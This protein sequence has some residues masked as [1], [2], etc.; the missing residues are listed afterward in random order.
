MVEGILID[1][2]ES[3]FI[4]TYWLEGKHEIKSRYAKGFDF[5]YEYFKRMRIKVRTFRCEKCGYL[6]N[7]AV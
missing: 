2:S 5:D 1:Q 6:E 3:A 7:Y 4:P